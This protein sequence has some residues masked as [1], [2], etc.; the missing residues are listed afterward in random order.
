[1]FVIASSFVDLQATYTKKRS[2]LNMK[3]SLGLSVFSAT[4]CLK[5]VDNGMFPFY[6]EDLRIYRQL[7]GW[8]NIF[9][10]Y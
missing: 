2:L 3:V 1:M 6:K 4:W 5:A 8:L 7:Q 9:S 10:L